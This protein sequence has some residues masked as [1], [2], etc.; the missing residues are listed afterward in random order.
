MR[1]TG[2]RRLDRIL[3][4][5][6]A[7]V[8]GGIVAIGGVVGDGERVPQM[9]V[10]AE[11][12]TEGAP[13]LLEVIDY[14]FGVVPKHGIFRT[15]P[16]LTPESRVEVVSGTA[17]DDIAGLTPVYI[18]GQSGTEVKIG[19]PNITI[20][21]RHRYRLDY[22]LPRDD[23]LDAADTLAWDAVGTQWTVGIQRAEV[24][25]LAP[26]ELL[27]ATCSVGRAGA[28]GGC[29]ARA[30]EPGHLVV[31]V[32]DLDAGEGVT[33]TA[34][35]GAA[36]AASP[37]V[38]APPTTA[39]PDPGIG[40]LMPAAGAAIAGLGA[41][42]TASTL[43]RRAGRERVGTGGVADAAW[44]ATGGPTAEVRMDEADLAEM[45]T[46]EFAPPTEVSPAQGGLL[47]AERVLPRHKVAWLIEQAIGGSI[48]LVEQDEGKVRLVR[49]AALAGPLATAF[50]GREAVELGT[51]DPTFASGWG[52]VDT[53]L[54]QWSTTSGLWD[55]LADARKLVVRV[56]GALVALLGAVLAFFGG[57][58]ANRWGGGWFVLVVVGSLLAGAGFAAVVRGW[59]LRVRTPLGSGLWLRVESFRRFLH[60]SE[61]FHAEE[62]AKRGVLREYT[63]WAVALDELDRW[64]RAVAGSTVIPQEAGL[65]YVHLAPALS[66]ST[67]SASTAPS[68][69]GGGGGGG[70]VGGGGGG[71][72]GGSW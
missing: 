70:S 68:S 7:L 13:R 48:D 40:L 66:H 53:E 14:D 39:P 26:W 54:R 42:L 3:L 4:G 57:F 24:H 28:E 10:G 63:A 72:G 69:S 23:L 43:V 46:T 34:E 1:T 12:S 41:G 67:A 64:E 32:E 52:Q 51:Y 16:G 58:A 61:T 5:L 21:G 59:E 65:G 45:A 36:L 55:P 56:L 33:I 22:E 49:K 60:Q 29:K 19:D 25:V 8:G 11:L 44:G 15:I 31:V 30:V 37:S 2:R 27:T 71:G 38:P 17:P 35:R 62:A 50:G 20:T 9:W 18:D 6:G 47:H